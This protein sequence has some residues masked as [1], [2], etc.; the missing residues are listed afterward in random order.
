[1]GTNTDDKSSARARLLHIRDSASPEAR[2]AASAAACLR[3]AEWLQE[4]SCTSLAAYAAFRSE[5]DL[6]PL[7][8]WA[9]R[10][11][12]DVLVPRVSRPDRSMT[13]HRLASWEELK[14]GAYGIM[15]PDPAAAPALPEG[16]LPDAVLVP[17]SGFDGKGGRLGYG[18]G[19]YDRYRIKLEHAARSAGREPPP[20]IGIGFAFQIVDAVPMEPHDAR[21]DGLITEE[22]IQWF[23]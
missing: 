20:W 6:S 21:L 12:I 15:E 10:A 3:A 9:W 13:L 17:G 1:M 19:Y 18:G 4:R 23:A 11:G 22:G 7:I 14:P 16:F 2:S 8:E 5:L